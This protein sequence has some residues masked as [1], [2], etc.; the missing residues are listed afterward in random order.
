MKAPQTRGFFVVES[1]LKWCEI[2]SEYGPNGNG[3]PYAKPP[4]S[5]GFRVSGPMPDRARLRTVARIRYPV[6]K[7]A[8]DR[9]WLP[10]RSIA[11]TS[12]L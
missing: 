11:R 4:L 7:A 2:A 9:V 12:Q 6:L 3:E 5:R 8:D 1:A 10:L